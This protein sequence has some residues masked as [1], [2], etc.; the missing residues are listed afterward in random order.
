MAFEPGRIFALALASIGLLTPFAIHLFLPVTPVLKTAF[1]ISDALAQISFSLPLL[2]MAFANLVYGALADRYG[3]RPVLLSGLSLFLLG[4]LIGLLADS[5]T[6]LIVARVVQAIGAGCGTTLVR[7]I[8]RDA[9]GPEKLVKVIS[10]LTMFYTIGPMISP[11]VAGLLLDHFSW[12]AVMVFSF[13]SGALIMIGTYFFVPETRP[14]VKL[15][16]G[17]SLLGNYREL[18]AHPRFIAYVL[19]PGFSTAVFFSVSASSAYIMKDMLHRPS[20]EFG[21]YFFLFPL[22][23]FSGN[24]V[25]SRIGNRVPNEIMVLAGSLILISSVTLQLFLL[26][27]G[28]VH[29]LTIFAIGFFNPFSQG[30]AMPYAQSAAMQIVPR[31]AGTAAGV[32][33]FSQSFLGAVFTQ[34]YGLMADGTLMPM[35]IVTGTGALLCLIFGTIPFLLRVRERARS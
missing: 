1:G 26:M 5:I 16:A 20:T 12:R 13:A 27:L 32:A 17:Q 4:S 8:A 2:V 18:F 31:L 6:A 24:F 30:I 29:P 34:T 7:A 11:T 19:Q 10:Y 25:S 28:Y 33:I 9:Y 14:G 22:G 3:R 21:L 15:A 35:I 23:F